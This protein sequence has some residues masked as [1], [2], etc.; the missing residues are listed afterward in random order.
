MMIEKS[1]KLNLLK[2]DANK[3]ANALEVLNAI[4]EEMVPGDVFYDDDGLNEFDYWQLDSAIVTLDTL[5]EMWG[6]NNEQ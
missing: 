3:L 5:I 2:E 4:A 6:R 1:I